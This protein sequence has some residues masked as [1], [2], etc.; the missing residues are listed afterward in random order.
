MRLNSDYVFEIFHVANVFLELTRA[1]LL[2]DEEAQWTLGRFSKRAR[3]IMVGR[4]SQ[5]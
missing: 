1:L 3:G 2:P 5:R 4:N